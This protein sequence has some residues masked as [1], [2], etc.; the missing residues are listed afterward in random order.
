MAAGVHNPLLA[1]GKGQLGALLNRQGVHVGANGEPPL[2]LVTGNFS[3]HAGLAHQLL[4]LQP[5]GRQHPRHIGR[6]FIFL[7]TQFGVT[8]QVVTNF[9][10]ARGKTAGEIFDFGE[11]SR[12]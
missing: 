8:V 1:G 6:R 4:H 7:T 11:H 12:W 3:H 9:R 2:I 10:E 5:A